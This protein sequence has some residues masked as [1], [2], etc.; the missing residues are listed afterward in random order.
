MAQLAALTD[1]C[2]QAL[3]AAGADPETQTAAT[4]AMLHASR[5]GVDSHGV[6]LLD[7]YVR[8]MRAG[9]VNARPSLSFSEGFG[10][11]HTLHADNAHGARATFAAIDRATG[12]AEQFGIGAVAIRD[13]SHFG[14]A[15]AYAL[16]AAS[17]GYLA[18][19]VCNSDSF[20]R[21]H[22]GAQRVHGTNPIAFAAP[23]GGESPWLLDMATSAVP[24]NR[25]LLS[26]SLGAA[27]PDGVASD[28]SGVDTADASLVDMLAP[29][30][31]AFGYKG[32]GLAGI[33]EILSAVLTGMTLSF[34]ILPMPGP[35]ITTPRRMGAFVLAVRPDAVVDREA[36]EAG[37][38]RYRDVLRAS[39]AREGQ[40]V[41]AP[42]DR[43][44][45]TATQR[46]R[47]GVPLDP[48]TAR[49][50]EAMAEEFGIALPFV[51]ASST[52]GG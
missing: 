8:V 16:H 3:A 24:Y 25:V 39:P 35:D 43:E 17:A 37:I 45:E 13:S 9:R 26:R 11:V 21:L 6:R 47:D 27:L 49:A 12:L 50:F 42:G 2:R 19:V 14:P 33:A 46:D 29:L 1:F 34:D 31:Q 20:V 36:Y 22:G 18:L 52:E 30:G 48:A 23:V 4:R 51:R 41:M 40:R 32:A 44:W 15:G 38:R 28:A 10:A 5:L 7:H